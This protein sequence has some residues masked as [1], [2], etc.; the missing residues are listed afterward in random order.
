MSRY[1]KT[2]SAVG[3]KLMYLI[4][5]MLYCNKK[6]FF[7][8]GW[9]SFWV[10]LSYAEVSHPYQIQICFPGN[11]IKAAAEVKAWALESE[12]LGLSPSADSL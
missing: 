7:F 10:E 6:V 2:Y 1:V 5:C 8:K 11:V 3:L 12:D 9:L 4:V